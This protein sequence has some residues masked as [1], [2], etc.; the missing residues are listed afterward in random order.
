MARKLTE[1]QDQIIA[2]IQSRSELAGLTSTS[3]TAIWRVLSYVVATAVWTLENLFDVF[4]AEVEEKLANLKPHSLRWYVRIAKS[5]QYG[6]ALVDGE[7]YYDNSALNDSEIEALQIVKHAAASESTGPLLLKIATE[8]SDVLAPLSQDQYDSFVAYIQLVKD[9]G[10]GIDVINVEGDKLRLTVDV[11]YDPLILLG[12]GGRA[13]GTVSA[14]VKDAIDEFLKSLPFDGVFV[15]SYLV[16]ALQG[17]EGVTVPVIR[18][19]DAAKSDANVLSQIDVNYQPYAGYLKIHDPVD[20]VIN[21]IP[22]V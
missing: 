8:S 18:V 14:P 22:Y 20:L 21:Y 10:V 9:A 13:D 17:V 3:S 7:D 4:K 5:F 16:D 12:N 19:C 2:Q 1:I 11:Y 6:S 15:K